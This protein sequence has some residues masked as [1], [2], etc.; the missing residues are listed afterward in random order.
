MNNVK[1]Q[2][3]KKVCLLFLHAITRCDTTS[4]LYGVGK[5]TVL[6]K[7]ENVFNFKKQANVFS[8]HSA[9]SDV[10]SIGSAPNSSCCLI[11]QPVRLPTGKAVAWRK[12]WHVNGKLAVES[13]EFLVS[14][15]LP[16]APE[17]LLHLI[18]RN[19]SSDCSSMR[20]ICRKTAMFPRLW[21]MQRVIRA[22]IC[23]SRLRKWRFGG[24][25]YLKLH[26]V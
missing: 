2:L 22:Q 5:A 9:V 1:E 16:P 13:Q 6:K 14:M 21:P 4:I 12:C 17:S 26:C 20:C 15:N 19:C 10:V 25:V 23:R 24:L 7:F 18:R 8:Y 3:G 11:S